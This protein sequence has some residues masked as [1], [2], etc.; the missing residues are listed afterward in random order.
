[1][2]TKVSA[3]LDAAVKTNLE[4]APKRSQ[5]FVIIAMLGAFLM[6]GFGCFLIYLERGLWWAPFVFS[7]IVISAAVWAFGVS[8]R[9]AEMHNPIA[10]ELTMTPD[11]L[12]LVTDPRLAEHSSFF[13]SMVDIFSALRN[14]K[15]LPPADALLDDQGNVIPGS[16]AAAKKAT[17]FANDLAK[18]LIDETLVAIMNRE[19]SKSLNSQA[20][21]PNLGQ[22]T[23][24]SHVGT[25]DG[26]DRH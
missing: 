9:N 22:E 18:R 11:G 17:D 5:I 24:L 25:D 16:A 15:P 19:E 23:D 12:R 7:V 10:S 6:A 8:H 21:P 1:M 26:R 14:Q 20:V 13:S 3:A 2:E 4:I